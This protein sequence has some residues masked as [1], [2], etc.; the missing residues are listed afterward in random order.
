MF[1]NYGQKAEMEEDDAFKIRKI[2]IPQI[3]KMNEH[4]FGV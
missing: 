3:N 4:I 2:R 1:Q